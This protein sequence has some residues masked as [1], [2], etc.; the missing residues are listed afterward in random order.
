MLAR[1]SADTHSIPVQVVYFH[2]NLE[3]FRVDTACEMKGA[4]QQGFLEGLSENQV[5]PIMPS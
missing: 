5:T 4:G 1:F 3:R 2:L